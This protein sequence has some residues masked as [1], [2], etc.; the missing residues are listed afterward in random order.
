MLVRGVPVASEFKVGYII[1][2]QETRPGTGCNRFLASPFC[3]A[4]TPRQTDLLLSRRRAVTPP[5]LRESA[6]V[7]AL[8]PQ[9]E[10]DGITFLHTHAV[11]GAEVRVHRCGELRGQLVVCHEL[12][13]GNVELDILPLDRA[14]HGRVILAVAHEEYPRVVIRA[15]SHR[16]HPCPRNPNGAETPNRL[17]NRTREFWPA[18]C[19]GRVVAGAM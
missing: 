13:S 7:H 9:G 4:K 6:L 15:Q 18:L 1:V 17:L 10:R 3:T 5:K 12:I 19:G 8:F 14:T 16:W 11:F 2:A